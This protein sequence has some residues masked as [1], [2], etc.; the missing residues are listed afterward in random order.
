MKAAIVPLMTGLLFAAAACP[1]APPG[2]VVT[3]NQTWTCGDDVVADNSQSVLAGDVGHVFCTRP[4][5]D[6]FGGTAGADERSADIAAYAASFADDCSGAN[7]RCLNPAEDGEFATCAA[8]C[9][10]AGTCDP[11]T[12]VR[13]RPN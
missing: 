12:T 2:E 8:T 1:E 4:G 13:V 6:A 9:V 5:T 7:I 11:E 10:V 3:C